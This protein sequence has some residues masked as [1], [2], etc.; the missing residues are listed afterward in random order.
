[1]RLR[2]LF[3]VL[4]LAFA[5]F[6]RALPA[7][8]SPVSPA[9]AAAAETDPWLGTLS[10]L[11]VDRYKVSG[12]LQLSWNRAR[13]ANA[14]AASDLVIINAPAELAPQILVTVRAT[15]EAGR[16]MDHTVIL[17]AELWRDGWILREPALTASA[18]D[19]VSLDTR[20]FDVLRE[21]EAIPADTS[22]ELNFARNVPAG[23][24]LTWRDVVRRPLVRRGQSV[25]V[26]ATDGNLIITLRAL[27]LQDAARGEPVRVRNPDSKKEF[28][29]LVVAESRASVRF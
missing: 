26:L 15:D 3:L 10:A 24:L 11:L 14:S 12:E 28:I 29:A 1:M 5:A 7:Q 2:F 21:R 17:R 20:R 22:A 19:I 9:P 4:S 23:R 25:E 8:T 13:P 27:A 6:V 18:V 16:V